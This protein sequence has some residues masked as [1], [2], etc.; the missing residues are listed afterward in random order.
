MIRGDV[1]VAADVGARL[2][3]EDRS[4]VYRY[5]SVNESGWLLAVMDGHS[6]SAEVA[7]FCKINLPIYFEKLSAFI[8]DCPDAVIED[9][10]RDAIRIL[11]EKTNNMSSGATISVVYISE[12]REKAFV[13]ILG[14]SPVIVRGAGSIWV[15]PEHNIRTNTKDRIAVLQKGAIYSNGYMCDPETYYGLQ[16]TRCLGDASFNN[17]LIREPE[18]FSINLDKNSLIIVASDGL[19][20]PAHEN[21]K[22]EL[23]IRLIGIIQDEEGTALDLVNDALIRQTGDNVSAIVWKQSKHQLQD[24]KMPSFVL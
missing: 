5:I 23:A 3:Q 24:G 22:D 15:S 2:Y 18:I 21:N 8:T 11:H 4:L 9:I 6:G 16:I 14:D 13:A 17:F 7:E 10:L 12:T 19:I 20:D 1:T